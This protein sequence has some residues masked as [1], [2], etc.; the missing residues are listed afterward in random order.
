MK[1]SIYNVIIA[2][3][4]TAFLAVQSCAKDETGTINTDQKPQVQQISTDVYK[5]DFNKFTVYYDCVEGGYV[6]FSTALSKDQGNNQRYSPFHQESALPK[7]CQKNVNYSELHDSKE[8]SLHLSYDKGHGIDNNSMDE[9]MQYMY[10][11][12]SYSNIVPQESNLNR[13]GTWREIEKIQN[14]YRNKEDLS[15][16]GGAIYEEQEYKDDNLPS[17]PKFLWKIVLF[18]ES[19]KSLSILV[20]NTIKNANGLN[21]KD[22]STIDAV[23]NEAKNI[24]NKQEAPALLA[25]QKIK[26]IE[27]SSGYKEMGAN[28]VLALKKGFKD[29]N[30]KN[31]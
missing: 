30:C 31:G 7:E 4:V 21:I 18:T 12:N 14:C 5:L 17:I 29:L 11:T 3:A 22:I 2:Y 23:L 26:Q 6:L 25:V 24:K 20:N 1:N 9:K 13:H 8:N 16:L 19:K 15:V 10:D 28:E 27:V